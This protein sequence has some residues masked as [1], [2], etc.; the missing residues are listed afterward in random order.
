MV[1]VFEKRF[2]VPYILF[3]IPSNIL[4]R[5][6]NL[7]VW[8]SG[9]ILAS[10]IMMLAQE[11]VKN[12]SGLFVTRFFLGLAEAGIFPGSFY[13]LSCWYKRDEALK[14]FAFYFS[15]VIVSNM[16]GGLLATTISKMDSDRG[17]YTWRWVFIL[18]SIATILIDFISYLALTDFPEETR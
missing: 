7:H 11:F 10:G 12:Y 14:R 6:F 13:I 8:L 9:C 5:R 4:L 2:I 15:S 18:E 16:F 1:L 17:Y 3:E